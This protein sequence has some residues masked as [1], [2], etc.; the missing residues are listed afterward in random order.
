MYQATGVSKAPYAANFAEM[1][2]ES[3][4]PVM[5]FGHHRAT[6]EIWCRMLAKYNPLLFT[7][8]ENRN[9]KEHNKQQFMAGKS[10]L[11]ICGLSSGVGI[12]GLQHR[13]NIGIF[14][15]LAW[16]PG[17]LSQ[18]MGR[19]HRDGQQKPCL[20]YLL[21]SE[22]GIDPYM[23]TTLGLKRLQVDGVIQAKQ[24]SNVMDSIDTLT[25]LRELAKK[26]LAA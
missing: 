20:S 16:S 2:L 8:S 24:S 12:D 7:G 26:F 4:E 5:L 23:L 19:Y 22:A 21:T 25:H 18:A 10:N 13:C 17:T 1:I 11:I 9:Q 3:G 14:G 6:F 15:E